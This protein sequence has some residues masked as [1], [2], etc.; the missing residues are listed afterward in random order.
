MRTEKNDCITL[1]R[2]HL[3]S[4][5]FYQDFIASTK[6]RLDSYKERLNTIAA[7]IAKYGDSGGGFSAGSVVEAEAEKRMTTERCIE[8]TKATLDKV[9]S[10]VD[11]MLA[12]IM[13]LPAD[14]REVA[15][16]FYIKGMNVVQVMDNLHMA[17]RTCY[18]IRGNAIRK[19]A[20]SLYG[21]EAT[22]KVHFMRII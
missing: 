8:E 19:I 10:L 11:R 12:A 4:L 2:K 6:K 21:P 13:L 16:A 15:E 9:Q 17:E 7:P 22:E 3:C 14:E 18:R 1:T 20:I 5:R